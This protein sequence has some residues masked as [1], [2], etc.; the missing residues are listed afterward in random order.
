MSYES[1]QENLLAEDEAFECEHCPSVFFSFKSGL[2]DHIEQ[3]HTGLR[4]PDSPE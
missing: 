2:E 4:L 3:S 1:Q